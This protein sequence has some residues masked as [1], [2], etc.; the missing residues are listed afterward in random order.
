M[1]LKAA[2]DSDWTPVD[3]PHTWFVDGK[4]SVAERV[5]LVVRGTSSLVVDDSDGGSGGSHQQV[6]R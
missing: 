3:Y 5:V 4:R 1:L 2:S 6:G